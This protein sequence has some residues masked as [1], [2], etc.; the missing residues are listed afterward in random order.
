MERPVELVQYV[1]PTAQPEMKKVETPE[2][3]HEVAEPIEEDKATQEQQPMER[4]VEPNTNAA[5]ENV[6]VKDVI[7]LERPKTRFSKAIS[8]DIPN[9]TNPETSVVYTYAQY[10]IP[11]DL[12]VKPLGVQSL[13]KHK[14][15]FN[16]NSLVCLNRNSDHPLYAMELKD[17][18]ELKKVGTLKSGKTEFA[19]AKLFGQ[20][21]L[22]YRMADGFGNI[23]NYVVLDQSI[24]KKYATN[25]YVQEKICCE[26][27][28][29]TQLRK[30]SSTVI[31][32]TYEDLRE[33]IKTFTPT[34]FNGSILNQNAQNAFKVLG[35]TLDRQYET[36]LTGTLYYRDNTGRKVYTGLSLLNPSIITL[37]TINVEKP[38]DPQHDDGNDRSIESKILN[39]IKAINDGETCQNRARF[40]LQDEDGN[41]YFSTDK[42]KLTKDKTLTIENLSGL[43]LLEH[44]KA[45][46][47][48][49]F[50]G[51]ILPPDSQ[52][53][54]KLLGL[55]I[56][57][58]FQTTEKGE[59]LTEDGVN[60]GVSLEIDNNGNLV[61]SCTLNRGD[62]EKL[63]G[64]RN[65]QNSLK[66]LDISG[67]LQS[68]ELERRSRFIIEIKDGRFYLKSEN[69]F[70]Y[71][72]MPVYL[73]ADGMFIHFGEA[74]Q[75][76]ISR[77]YPNQYKPKT[78]DETAPK[79]V[80]IST[81]NE[82]KQSIYTNHIQTLLGNNP[83]FCQD[84][85]KSVKDL[86][87]YAKKL[88]IRT[89]SDHRTSQDFSSSQFQ[90]IAENLGGNFNYLLK[91]YNT[92]S[93]AFWLYTYNQYKGNPDD[94]TTKTD[95]ERINND[96][97]GKINE[98]TLE[99]RS[100]FDKQDIY[101]MAQAT[102]ELAEYYQHAL[103]FMQS[104]S[105]K[106]S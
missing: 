30:V 105:P 37:S 57:Q 13:A 95:F 14:D 3:K 63:P 25:Q 98:F 33:Q 100:A 78:H 29:E 50:N 67:S 70:I 26:N 49:V 47:P 69:D 61:N 60:T 24:A 99:Y 91:F 21:R 19:T 44:L 73:G 1:N 48:T 40:F 74:Q 54:L 87:K 85:I 27:E 82:Y 34:V 86:S 43:F 80:T 56:N 55:N 76:N 88:M 2:E 11:K 84:S 93:P 92:L 38:V 18:V 6:E 72:N 15:S 39:V 101:G 79:M 58:T 4:P 68:N 66:N 20:N 62:D 46:T 36:E 96:P 17:S 65:L 102:K 52:K 31:A 42:S 45:A 59:I 71:I 97:V 106:A 41:C 9:T 10:T 83:N 53:L 90:N 16:M 32:K 5:A 28:R 103:E 8:I 64:L 51:T 104:L 89:H 81:T 7:T 12:K 23:K 35:L 94:A 22:I 75:Y 77:N